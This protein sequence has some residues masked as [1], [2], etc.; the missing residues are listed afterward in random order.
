MKSNLIKI[1]LLIVVCILVYKALGGLIAILSGIL[2]SVFI[3]KK[4]KEWIEIEKK[5]LEAIKKEHEKN[6]K[7]AEELEK[8]MTDFLEELKRWQK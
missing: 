8:E 6:K 3:M 4:N 2:G 7:D 1:I 5:E